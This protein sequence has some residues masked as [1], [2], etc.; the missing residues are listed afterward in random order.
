MKRWIHSIESSENSYLQ[1]RADEARKEIDRLENK[2][3]DLQYR[4][5]QYKRTG[6]RPLSDEDRKNICKWREEINMLK[7]RLH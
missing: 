4:E 1:K 7:R 3:H 6:E 2:I 5:Q